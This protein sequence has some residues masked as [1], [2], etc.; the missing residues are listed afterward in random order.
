MQ[1]KMDRSLK[2]YLT[3]RKSIYLIFCSVIFMLFPVIDTAVGLLYASRNFEDTFFSP[4]KIYKGMIFFYGVFLFLTKK[5]KNNN[6]PHLVLFGIIIIFLDVVNTYFYSLGISAVFFS[7]ASS[8]QSIGMFIAVVYIMEQLNVEEI[9]S[10]T[11]RF[12]YSYYF[13]A[14]PIIYLCFITGYGMMTYSSTE[15]VTRGFFRA[16]NEISFVLVSVTWVLLL[17][18]KFTQ[19]SF[20]IIFLFGGFAIYLLGTKAGLVGLMFIATFKCT[21]LFCKKPVYAL[22]FNLL[23]LGIILMCLPYVIYSI[24]PYLPAGDRIEYFI[25]KNNSVWETMFSGRDELVSRGLSVVH[26]FNPIQLFCGIGTASFRKSVAYSLF[27]EHGDYRTVEQDWLDILGANGII[28]LIWF[29]TIFIIGLRYIIHLKKEEAVMLSGLFM[30]TALYAN[31]V[32]H[33]F[34]AATPI[35]CF[36]F[37]F[38]LA[39]REFLLSEKYSNRKIEKSG[40]DENDACPVL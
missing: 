37:V 24:V 5:G 32:G 10:V 35:T 30:F 3:S 31:F 9:H 28:G 2:A 26:S 11:R 14:I 7:L 38:L 22:V 23:L 12:F 4:G 1:E 33:L 20:W 39:K 18:K 19:I 29:A 6:Y 25:Q 40:M 34:V 15:A 8:L 13:V 16:G 27:G 21:A 36:A 17:K